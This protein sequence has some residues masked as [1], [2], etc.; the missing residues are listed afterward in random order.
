MFPLLHLLLLGTRL[1]CVSMPLHQ[2]D[3]A[4]RAANGRHR[5]RPDAF[6]A[7]L[8]TILPLPRT[9]LT[10]HLSRLHRRAEVARLLI[11]ANGAFEALKSQV[12]VPPCHPSPLL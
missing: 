8:M 4:V 9:S 6:L 1:T 7:T 5:K 3:M 12:C 11:A 2:L 10:K